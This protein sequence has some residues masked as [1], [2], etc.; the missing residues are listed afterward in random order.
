MYYIEALE[1]KQEILNE[2]KKQNKV[3]DIVDFYVNHRNGAIW[4]CTT[5]QTINC[6]A[7]WDHGMVLEKIYGLIYDDFVKWSKVLN[8]QEEAVG[9]KGNICIQLC[10]E[11][12]SFI[13]IPKQINQRQY[14]D[15][16][17]FLEKIDMANEQLRKLGKD[18]IVLEYD[19][20][21]IEDEYVLEM[22]KEDILEEVERRVKDIKENPHEHLLSEVR[23]T[24]NKKIEDDGR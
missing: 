1:D 20:E 12:P 23:I 13:W 5:K 7:L 3:F 4:V 19:L 16:C 8:W 11:Y 22:K 24:T 17:R 21:G 14:D 15:F 10:S 2:V 6:F 18:D 9:L